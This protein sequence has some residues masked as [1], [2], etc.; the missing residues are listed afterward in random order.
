MGR[1]RK[2]AAEIAASLAAGTPHPQA[3]PSDWKKR[4]TNIQH[5]A[6]TT[7]DPN[8][9]EVLQR[10]LD[11]ANDGL[12]ASKQVAAHAPTFVTATNLSALTEMVIEHGPEFPARVP[13]VHAPHLKRTLEAGLVEVVGNRA[14]L[15]RA[16]RTAVADLLVQDIARESAWHPRENIFVPPERRAEIMARDVAEHDAKVRRLEDTL[17]KIRLTAT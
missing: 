1:S 9:R 13:A 8:V 14:R 6:R 16:G 5:R 3:T 15:T 2:L 17:A 4:I 7:N 10:E 12:R 11:A